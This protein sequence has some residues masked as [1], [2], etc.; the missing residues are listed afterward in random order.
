MHEKKMWRA[1]LRAW[2]GRAIMANSKLNCVTYQMTNV[3]NLYP[4][5][6]HNSERKN[7]VLLHGF[8]QKTKQ[9]NLVQGKELTG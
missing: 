9:I 3:V 7:Q 2:N 4:R 8:V 5:H 6:V 1:N